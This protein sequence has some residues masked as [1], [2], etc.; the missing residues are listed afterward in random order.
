MEIPAHDGR[1]N[2]KRHMGR[3]AKV[4]LVPSA[5]TALVFIPILLREPST[6]EAA[7]PVWLAALLLAPPIAAYLAAR[8]LGGGLHLASSF[9]IGLPQLPLVILLSTAAIWLDVQRGHL[10]PGSGEEAMSYGIGTVV[11]FVAG[12][13]LAL[14]V[15]AAAS[16]GA[17]RSR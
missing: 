14:L 7:P 5:V 1:Q 3:A 8:R 12:T 6:T 4:A 13:V 15:A 9:L 2:G 16:L 10:L 11:A 17:R